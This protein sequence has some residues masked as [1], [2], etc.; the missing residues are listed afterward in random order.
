MIFKVSETVQSVRFIEPCFSYVS[1]LLALY[2]SENTEPGRGRRSVG[3]EASQQS[4]WDMTSR[5]EH[6]RK[7]E[8]F[9]TCA[10]VKIVIKINRFRRGLFATSPFT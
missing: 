6:E 3:L 1:A 9:A 10:N 7:S 5:E 4:R 8:P 2:N